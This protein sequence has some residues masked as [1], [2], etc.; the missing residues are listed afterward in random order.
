MPVPQDIPQDIRFNAKEKRGSAIYLVWRC[1]ILDVIA[2][3][4]QEIFYLV[5]EYED[6]C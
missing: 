1:Q 2:A 5:W 3:T 4:T 6:L